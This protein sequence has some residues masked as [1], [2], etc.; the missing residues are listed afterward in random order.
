MLNVTVNTDPGAGGAFAT[1]GFY[2]YP[3]TDASPPVR[4]T[5]QY[6]EV[7]AGGGVAVTTERPAWRDYWA[8]FY[9]YY[10]VLGCEYE[11]ICEAPQSTVGNDA[12]IGVQ[13]DTYSDT[14][15]ST[16][17]VMPLSYYSDVKTFKNIQWHRVKGNNAVNQG[18]NKTVIKGVY[19]PGQA[20]RNIT[21]DGDVK[22][23][24]ATSTTLPNL[25]EILT[26][27]FWKHP[28][29]YS[30]VQTVLNMEINLKYLVQFKDLKQQGRYPNRITTNQDIS[31]TLNESNS[32]AGT[33]HQLW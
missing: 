15:T 32:A 1:A 29:N 22:T 6:P 5:E 11:I 33:A 30:G 26:L 14:A 3:A 24:T 9:D 25:K 27:N 18:N 7:I 10:T 8:S 28:M 23:W 17:N 4:S 19:K 21:N 13:F 2:G 20:K 12:I 16:G 31:I